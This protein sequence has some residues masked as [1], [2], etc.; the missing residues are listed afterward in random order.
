M[1]FDNIE[2]K[3]Y[4]R[5][6]IGLK[7]LATP[8]AVRCLFVY[9]VPFF[10][11]PCECLTPKVW[12][13]TWRPA[14]SCRLLTGRKYGET[15]SRRGDRKAKRTETCACMS[16][17]KLI[18]IPGLARRSKKRAFGNDRRQPSKD[19]L[20]RRVCAHENTLAAYSTNKHCL[21]QW[22]PDVLSLPPTL[23]KKIR[24][25]SKKKVLAQNYAMKN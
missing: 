4:N 16:F 11:V 19:R 9:G 10:G 24:P 23:K 6:K 8:L 17:Q 18:R 13:E 3:P 5:L 7:I 21:N 14:R 12:A 20:E 2:L 1:H 15:S 22:F 25:S